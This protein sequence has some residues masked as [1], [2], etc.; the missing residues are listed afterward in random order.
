[1]ELHV[2]RAAE[3]VGSDRLWELISINI[4]SYSSLIKGSEYG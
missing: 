2:S 4:W 1:M 3:I